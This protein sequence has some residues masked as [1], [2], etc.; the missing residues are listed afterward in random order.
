[1]KIAEVTSSF[2][3]Y[4]GGIGNVAYYNAWSLATLGHDVTV[5]TPRYKH[6]PKN[7][8]DEYPFKVRRLH[9]WF[10]YGNAGILPQLLF[11]LPQYDLIHL[12]YP[13]FGGSEVIYFLDKVKDLKLVITYH[14]DVVG[15]GVMAKFFK[16]HTENVLPRILDRADKIIITS[17][18]YAKESSL[19]ERIKAEPEK[20]VEIPCGV[21]HLLFKPRYR[22]KTIVDEYSLHD[23]KVIL[24]FSL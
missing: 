4:K 7:L 9:P 5:F 2:P 20:F 15:R 22:D 18:D 17:W 24:F 21:N 12:H 10:R 8:V 11:E 23:K 14:M 19:S 6:T 3:P 13:F 1:M 16:W